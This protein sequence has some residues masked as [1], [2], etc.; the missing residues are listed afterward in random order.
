MENK[1]YLIL[2]HKKTYKVSPCLIR[3]CE[4]DLEIALRA[5]ILISPIRMTNLLEK[6]NLFNKYQIIYIDVG[7]K[8]YAFKHFHPQI[9]PLFYNV[10]ILFK[11]YP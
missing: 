5:C 6:N 8:F 10:V 4:S 3:A 2:V 7:F 1:E 9:L 11:S